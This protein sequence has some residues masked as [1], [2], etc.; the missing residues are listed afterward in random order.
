MKDEANRLTLDEVSAWV[1]AN[2]DRI[3]D[4]I[5]AALSED[6]RP[7]APFVV[8]IPIRSGTQMIASMS[9]EAAI[10]MMRACVM[11]MQMKELREFVSEVVPVIEQAIAAA[12]KPP[13]DK[14]N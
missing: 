4:G 10:V 11:S 13:A 3:D 6:G 1:E 2:L 7:M 12:E 5:R 9:T 14:L 8:L